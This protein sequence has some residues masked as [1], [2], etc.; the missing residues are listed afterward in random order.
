QPVLLGAK[1]PVMMSEAPPLARSAKYSA[2]A[3]NRLNRSSRPTCIEPI[4]TRLGNVVK[5]RSSG[6]SRFGYSLI[7]GCPFAVLAHCRQHLVT[8]LEGA[9]LGPDACAQHEVLVEPLAGQIARVRKVALLDGQVDVQPLGMPVAVPGDLLH[10]L[11]DVAHRRAPHF[12]R[13]VV[14]QRGRFVLLGQPATQFRSARLADAVHLLGGPALLRHRL[15][16][17][18]AE[19]DHALERAVDLLVAGRPEVSDRLVEPAGQ[20]VAGTRLLLQRHQDRMLE[21]HASTLIC[22]TTQCNM[23]HMSASGTTRRQ[24]PGQPERTPSSRATS[25]ATASRAGPRY[26]RVST[27][28]GFS[29]RR[30]RTMSVNTALR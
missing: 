4:T 26:L 2:H 16:V 28:F 9:L 7:A 17:D 27:S 22:N 25:A 24:P 15:D 20:F 13:Q 12:D 8:P 19:V 5:P 6:R 14:T 29:A 23:L 11:V 10:D 3:G 1:P 18:P 21:R 30:E